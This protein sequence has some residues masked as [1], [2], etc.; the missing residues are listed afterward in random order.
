[1]THH[2]PRKPFLKLSEEET[3]SNASK[4]IEVIKAYTVKIDFESYLELLCN[5]KNKKGKRI[6]WKKKEVRL[7]TTQLK[8]I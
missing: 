1:M 5:L 3:K 4:F 7:F 6:Y 2:I 8:M